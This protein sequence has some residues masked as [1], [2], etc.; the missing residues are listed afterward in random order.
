MTKAQWHSGTKVWRHD[1]KI[2]W[3][4]DTMDLWALLYNGTMVRWLNS[5]MVQWL[6]RSWEGI[7]TK[8]GQCGTTLSF[9]KKQCIIQEVSPRLWLLMLECCLYNPFSFSTLNFGPGL[10]VFDWLIGA[11]DGLFRNL[12]HSFL[13]DKSHLANHL[14]GYQWQQ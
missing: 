12:P 11:H 9:G 4:D 14:W 10:I 5:L 6:D 8:N 7:V 3:I 13:V 2:R 1:G